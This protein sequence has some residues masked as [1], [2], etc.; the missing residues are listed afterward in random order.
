MKRAKPA[1][2]DTAAGQAPALAAS[3]VAQAF[4]SLSVVN[5]RFLL[6]GTVGSSFAMWMEQIGQGWLVAQLT[7]SPFQLGLVQFIRGVSVLFVSP[8]AGAVSE[9]VDRR[10]LAG[11]A[12]MANGLS[13]LSIGVLILT[14]HIAMWQLYIT[15][16]IGGFSSSIYNPVRQFLVFDAVGT[17]HLPNAI[18]LNAMV[19]N[20]ARVVGPGLAGFLISYSLSS[21]F[22][23]EFLFFVAATLSLAQLRLSQTASYEREPVLTSVRLGAGYMLRHRLLLRLT[24]LQAIPSMLIY[25]Y[26]QLMPLMAKDYLHVGSVGYGWLQTGVGIGAL[27]SALVVASFADVRHRGALASVALLVYMTMI[28]SFS[29]SRHYFLSLS[30][31]I[32]GGMGL[33]VFSTFNQTLLQL[34]VEDD[35]RG[36][37]LSLYTMAQGLNP[38]GA[39][40]MGFVASQFLGTA[41][42]IAAFCIVALV[43]AAA[44]GIASKEIRSL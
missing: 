43:L 17:K 42:A 23:G 11:V 40:A 21:V 5:F 28:L 9:R 38:L 20:M 12:S 30:L 24:L 8:F 15:A 41:H 18:A 25:P 31:L 32:M 16:F 3:R 26:L 37:V 10:L 36:R 35:Y 13:A 4:S 6:G 39:L 1:V 19:N 44:S 34:H 7:N 27:V 22:F 14:G 29:F 2:P 33:V